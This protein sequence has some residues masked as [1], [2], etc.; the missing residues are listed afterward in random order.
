MKKIVS[1]LSINLLLLL[2]IVISSI[3]QDV[4]KNAAKHIV[5]IKTPGHPEHTMGT[6]FY[7]LYKGKSYILTNK[8]ICD[9]QTRILTEYGSRKVIAEAESQDICLVESEKDTG[10]EIAEFPAQSLDKIHFI[11]FPQGNPLTAREG[12]IVGMQQYVFPWLAAHEI[13]AILIT[14]V[15]FPGSSGSP[16]LNEYGKV[17]GILFAVNMRTYEDAFMVPLETLQVFMVAYAR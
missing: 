9:G 11:G 15:A 2:F 6:G 7:V 5:A 8:H 14:A 16:I 10:L 3:E 4:P 1:L 17:I 12:R 13:N